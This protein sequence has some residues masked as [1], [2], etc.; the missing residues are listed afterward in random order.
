MR[1]LLPVILGLTALFFLFLPRPTLAADLT[2][3]CNDS[4]CSPATS[5]S[6]F[7]TDFW[8]PGRSVSRQVA[9]TNTDSNPLTVSNQAQNTAVTGSLDTVMLLSIIRDS[10]STVLWSGTLHD[11]YSAGNVPLGVLA[12]GHSESFDYV[13]TMDSSAGNEYQDKETSYDLVL[14]FSGG[15]APATIT[16]GGGGTVAGASTP[17]CNDTAPA[18]A[19]VLTGIV[20]GTNSVTLFWN[21][22]ADPVTYYLV[23]Y[24][25]D[26]AAD[27]FG[28]PNVGGAGT[29]SY[30]VGGL[31]G[32]VTYYFKVRA[33]NGCAPGPFSNILS[34]TPGGGVVSGPAAG[35]IPGVLGEATPSAVLSTPSGETKGAAT[36][37]VCSECVWWPFLLLEV[38]T[39]ALLIRKRWLVRALV[40]VAVF[41][42]WWFVNRYACPNFF[43]QWFWLLDILV[44]LLAIP[45]ARWLRRRLQ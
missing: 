15:A 39:L 36:Q 33:G 8:F 25:T 29:T 11:F 3:S 37:A 40:P 4:G 44:F 26:P 31:S 7:P 2:V 34:V 5:P 30:T 18:G 12:G 17:V 32:G 16:T 21:K 23:A 38:V 43:C 45:V 35:F 41:I 19:P 28:N 9:V 13:V 22:A 14:Y 24:G 27:Q 10:D 1:K 20:A 6:I 42:L